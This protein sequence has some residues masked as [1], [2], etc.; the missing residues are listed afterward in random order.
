MIKYSDI[1]TLL[2]RITKDEDA[3]FEMKRA[4]ID[5]V[6]DSLY[7]TISLNS[8]M[9]HECDLLQDME[10]R[11]ET[12][13]KRPGG[14]S[15]DLSDR[16]D[17]KYDEIESLRLTLVHNLEAVNTLF[18]KFDMKARFE[19]TEDS[20]YLEVAREVEDL[21]I[22]M[23]RNGAENIMDVFK[24][25]NLTLSEQEETRKG[26]QK[27]ENLVSNANEELANQIQRERAAQEIEAAEVEDDGYS[28]R[29]AKDESELVFS[30]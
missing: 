18:E 19:V 17:A 16:L 24:N 21:S 11:A 23:I 12:A 13:M 7:S 10:R 6:K 29:F 26:L 30:I 27:V 5:V 25:K 14:I 8:K 1:R 28:S 4:E 9:A 2:K 22:G 3:N 15:D 20:D